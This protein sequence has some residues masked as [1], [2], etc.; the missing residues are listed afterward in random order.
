[1]RSDNI[2]T[3]CYKGQFTEVSLSFSLS[4][5]LFESDG[6]GIAVFRLHLSPDVAACLSPIIV[7]G[8]RWH[9]IVVMP[10]ILS[11]VFWSWCSG[12]RC[13]PRTRG[14]N[15]KD[16]LG[17]EFFRSWR[18]LFSCHRNHLYKSLISLKVLFT[19]PG[20]L[21]PKSWSGSLSTIQVDI[22]TNVSVSGTL[23]AAIVSMISSAVAELEWSAIMTHG[24]PSIE[25]VSP[26]AFVPCYQAMKINNK[27]DYACGRT[28]V[29]I[30]NPKTV[31]FKLDCHLW[32]H[33]SPATNWNV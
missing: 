13:S 19:F 29:F 27:K 16:L 28:K 24:T 2:T 5:S 21:K 12:T 18:W 32:F 22:D 6:A 15:G 7:L 9:L 14:Q 8:N 23:H 4:L 10:L 30:R 17:K 1:M 31:S 33:W 3:Q 26:L 20:I 11:F 25:S